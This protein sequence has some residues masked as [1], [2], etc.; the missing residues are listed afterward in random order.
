MVITANPDSING[1]LDSIFVTLRGI[2]KFIEIDSTDYNFKKIISKQHIYQTEKISKVQ[3]DGIHFK[4]TVEATKMAG[5][6]KPIYELI[7]LQLMSFSIYDDYYNLLESKFNGP[8]GIYA[9]NDYNYK[10]LDT[11]SIQNRKVY[12]IHFTNKKRKRKMACKVFYTLMQKI[13][14]L[15]KLFYVSKV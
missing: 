9:L 6:K 4:E 1:T 3:F 12:L 8:L 11:L 13:T 10:I 7:G 15:Q 2:R 14:L 5:F